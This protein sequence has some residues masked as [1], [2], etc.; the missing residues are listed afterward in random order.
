MR[1]GKG[2][3]VCLPFPN[4]DVLMKNGS[5]AV[6]KNFNMIDRQG[7]YAVRLGPVLKNS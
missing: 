3:L 2:G 7:T 1:E 6:Q 5:R 4:V